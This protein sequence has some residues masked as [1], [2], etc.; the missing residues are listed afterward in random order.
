MEGILPS[1]ILLTFLDPSHFLKKLHFLLRSF[2]FYN[3]IKTFLDPSHFS[4]KN[5]ISFLDPSHLQKIYIS[6]LDPSYFQKTCISC[7][8]SKKCTSDITRNITSLSFYNTIWVAL[9]QNV[10]QY[11]YPRVKSHI[12]FHYTRSPLH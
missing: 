6:F 1:Q 4:K 8:F 11:L 5:Y 7:H 2:S 3:C 10:L 12:S 9:M